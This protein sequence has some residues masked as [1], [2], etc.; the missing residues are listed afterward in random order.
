M[1]LPLEDLN[2]TPEERDE[3]LESQLKQSLESKRALI[4]KVS[5]I[6]GHK[7]AGNAIVSFWL[8]YSSSWTFLWKRAYSNPLSP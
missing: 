7:Y 2:V 4:V 3:N 6:G 5:H 1:G 8:F